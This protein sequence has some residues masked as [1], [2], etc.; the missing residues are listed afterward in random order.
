M[1]TQGGG[2]TKD[3]SAKHMFDRIGKDVYETVEK[4]ADDKKYKDELKGQ[5]SQVSVK[6]ETVSSN[7]TCN[8]VQKYYE[9]FNGG[10]GG[11]GER[12]PCKKLSGKDAKKERFSDTLGGQCTDQQIEGNDQKQKIGA[13]APYRRLHLCHHNL[14]T[15]DTKSTTSD[16]AKHNLLAEVCMA[17]KYEGNSIDTPYIIHQQTNEGSQLCTVLA[18]SFA[19][20]GDIVRGRDLFHGNP[21]ESAQRIILDDKLKKIFQQIHEGLND[22]IK[23]N[24]DDN[25]GNYYKLREDW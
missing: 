21:Q 20:I 2:G 14:E 15:I 19:D 17:A 13:C 18:R 1:S 10:G 4:D 23:S 8:L 22:K 25:G 5:L 12:Y 9:H 11:K 7:D 3:P 24:Y 6:L 16:N